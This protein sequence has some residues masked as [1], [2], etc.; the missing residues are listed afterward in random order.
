LTWAVPIILLAAGM[1]MIRDSGS[2]GTALTRGGF[3]HSFWM[4]VGQFENEEIAGFTDWDVC[5]L[6]SELGYGPPCDPSYTDPRLPYLYQYRLDY[7]A[8]LGSHAREWI[9]DNIPRMTRNAVFRLGWMAIPGLMDSSKLETRPAV[10][11]MVVLI[12]FAIFLLA[13]AATIRAVSHLEGGGEEMIILLGTYLALVPLTPYYIIAK[14][15]MVSYFCVLAMAS[16]GFLG[17]WDWAKHRRGNY[18]PQ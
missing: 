11:F 16:A 5:D 8:L 18:F 12:S 4:G 13:L 2:T 9:P 14:V 10:R 3:W 15:V 1:I 7:N 6:A 17:L